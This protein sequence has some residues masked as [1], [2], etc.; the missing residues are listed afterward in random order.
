[1]NFVK[2]EPI[3]K[4]WSGDLKYRVTTADGSNYLLRITPHEKKKNRKGMFDH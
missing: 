2:K 1:M 4:G 3:E